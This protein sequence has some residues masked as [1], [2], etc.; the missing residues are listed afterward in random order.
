M[1]GL[2]ISC[3]S[4]TPATAYT[5]YRISK[6]NKGQ[7][8]YQ[9]IIRPSWL[10]GVL[11]QE[12]NLK[13]RWYVRWPLAARAK[14]TSAR[15][16]KNERMNGKDTTWCGILHLCWFNRSPPFAVVDSGS[17]FCRE[18]CYESDVGYGTNPHLPATHYIVLSEISKS[19]YNSTGRSF[20]A[21]D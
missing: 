14:K 16:H 1:D 3:L 2:P 17:S 13:P 15:E 9:R 18:E 10:H 8:T 19:S 6:L 12:S 21:S 20:V 5:S 7:G 4:S 11:Q